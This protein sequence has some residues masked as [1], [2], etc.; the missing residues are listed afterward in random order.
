MSCKQYQEALTEAALGGTQDAALRAHL[1]GCAGCR[2]EL[3]RLRAL[4]GAM[5]R[6][7]VEMMNVE[8][9]AGFA[10]RVRARVAEESAARAASW[11]GWVPAFAGGIAVLTLAAWLLWPDAQRPTPPGAPAMAKDEPVAP[12]RAAPEAPD[13]LA[14]A[15]P[16]PEPREVAS[17]R[18]LPV[19]VRPQ[20][21]TPAR[22]ALPEVLVSGDEWNQ[23]LKLYALGQRGQVEAEAVAPPDTTPLEAK[24]RSLEI[25]LL[26]PIAPLGETPQPRTEPRK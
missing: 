23:V 5:D 25:A 21:E 6:G 22:P 12:L 16:A 19:P 10:A 18:R 26:Q 2:N 24:F 14:P 11:R 3:H 17:V 8:P 4:T 13:N 9:S 7:I 15:P 1:A 20:R